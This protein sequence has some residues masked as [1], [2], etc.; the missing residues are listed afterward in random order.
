MLD[1]PDAG[2]ATPLISKADAD[3]KA[4][5]KLAKTQTERDALERAVLGSRLDTLQEKVAWVLNRYTDARDSDLILQSRYWDNFEHMAGREVLSRSDLFKLTALTSLS[6]A[7]AKVQNTYKLFLASDNVRK[8]RGTLSDEEKEKARAQRPPSQLISVFA[9]ES[10]KTGKR[11]IIGTVWILFPPEEIKFYE[12]LRAWRADRPNFKG[13]FHFKEIGRPQLQTYKEFADFLYSR[14]SVLS[15]KA[16]SVE[17]AGV[18]DTDKTLERLQALLLRLGID[19]ENQTRRAQL[20]RQLNYLWDREKQ[21]GADELALAELRQT[22]E[23]VANHEYGGSLS[24]G[25]FKAIDSAEN[26]FIQI[27]DLYTGSI[28]RLFNPTETP[29][30]KDEFAHYFLER[31]GTPE[32][33]T[34]E[35]KEGDLTVRFNL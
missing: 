17:R 32:G 35:Q 8:H 22:M 24:L 2:D 12:D 13:E 27:A 31:L 30:P 9:D 33:P 26:P 23:G 19:H 18:G 21:G 25:I 28:N 3:A 10:G 29:G 20:P 5:E 7:R 15:F 6:R 1:D 16:I 34:T 14:T 4:A 11:L